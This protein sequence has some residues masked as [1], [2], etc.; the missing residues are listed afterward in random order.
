VFSQVLDLAQPSC[1]VG[2]IA[3]DG[4]EILQLIDLVHRGGGR[5]DHDERQRFLGKLRETAALVWD[6]AHGS[7][8][9]QSMELPS[10]LTPRECDVLELIAQG[11][12][13]KAIA[14][15]LGLGPETVKT[16][17]K[18]V[19]HKLAVERRTQAVLRAE[20]LGLLRVHRSRRTS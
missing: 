4:P 15:K 6:P 14:R 10:P 5:S 8:A 3:D 1:L 12:S 9:A 18:N 2:S 16:H 17:L 19:F 7:T 13:N 11:Q 20:E